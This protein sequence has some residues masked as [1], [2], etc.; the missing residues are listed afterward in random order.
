MLSSL[1]IWTLYSVFDTIGL[2]KAWFSQARR[3][4]WNLT[5]P[6]AEDSESSS[7]LGILLE[8]SNG[9]KQA[10]GVIDG[11]VVEAPVASVFVVVESVGASD[12]RAEEYLWISTGWLHLLP[13]ARLRNVGTAAAAMVRALRR[14]DAEANEVRAAGIAQHVVNL[15]LREFR[16][17]CSVVSEDR[18]CLKGDDGGVCWKWNYYIIG[19]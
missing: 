4:I 5:P 3:L 13:R 19:S 18:S 8:T 2:M 14:V 15:L 1:Q 11:D 17:H 6:G 9:S 16:Q 7:L 12:E 10:S